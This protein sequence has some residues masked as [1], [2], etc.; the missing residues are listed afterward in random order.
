MNA[1]EAALLDRAEPEPDEDAT[2]EEH[3]QPA[4]ELHFENIMQAP[5]PPLPPPA[6]PPVEELQA[7]LHVVAPDLLLEGGA[8]G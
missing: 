1:L 4:P 3:R 2:D 8:W 6:E 7:E 5:P